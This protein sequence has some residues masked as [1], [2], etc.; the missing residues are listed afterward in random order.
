MFSFD[1]SVKEPEAFE[2]PAW[3]YLFQGHRLLVHADPSETN[4]LYQPFYEADIRSNWPEIKRIHFLGAKDSTPCYVAE[5]DRDL[6]LPAEVK[7]MSLR[8]LFGQMSKTHLGIAGRAIQILNWDRNHQ[9]CGRCGTLTT[10]TDDDRAKECP[11]CK[12]RAYPRLSPAVIMAVTHG[13]KLLLGR[14]SRHPQGFYSVLA[15]FAEPGETLEETVTREVFEEVGLDV[16][17]IRYFGSQPWPFPDSLMI[18]FT[19]EYASGDISL[20]DSEISEAEWYSVDEIPAARPPAEI[21][22]AG[23]LIDWFIANNTID[24]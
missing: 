22:I 1:S 7:T 5:I 11:S 20:T 2:Q 15:G 17:N 13:E 21:S 6:T 9:Y 19:C 8:R 10:I 4:S 14:S 23:Q 16:K 3:W 12:L 18:G 24:R